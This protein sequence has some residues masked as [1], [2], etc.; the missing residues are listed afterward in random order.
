MA[1]R[2]VLMPEE[3]TDEMVEIFY[4]T[5]EQERLNSSDYIP[6]ITK[7]LSALTTARPK[8]PEEVV[9]RA[10]IALAE[11]YTPGVW[12]KRSGDSRWQDWREVYMKDARAVIAALAGGE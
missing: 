3:P 10:A 12:S 11:R 6:A 9:E 5:L 1:E 2:Y 4:R 7:A 8:V